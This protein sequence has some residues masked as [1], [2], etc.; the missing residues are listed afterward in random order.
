MRKANLALSG[1]LF[2]V[3]S[4]LFAIGLVVSA[5]EPDP[6][7]PEPECD[8]DLDCPADKLCQAG[9]CV[10]R[11]PKEAPPE[12]YSNADCPDNKICVA[13][14]CVIECQSDSDCPNGKSCIN[15]R[16]VDAGCKVPVVYFDFD[17]YYLTS[18][19]QSTLRANAG[20]LKEF[21]S[22]T[23]VIEGHCDERGTAEYNL[24]LG[25]KRAQAVRDF[26]VDLG[27]D[28]AAI[29]IISYGEERPAEYGSTEAAWA[30]N[31]RAEG[32]IE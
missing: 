17:Q 22:K 23:I 30:K 26:V 1:A 7:P 12:C 8:D 18:E 29:K 25:Q 21:K 13:G 2:L 11:A 20:C 14:K 16:C 10:T 9:R 15:N 6:P 3:L 19:A 24:S 31:R 4:M 5:C 28:P 27:I 32:K